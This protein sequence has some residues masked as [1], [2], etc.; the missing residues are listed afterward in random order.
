MANRIATVLALLVCMQVARAQVRIHSHND[1]FRDTP[2]FEAYNQRVGSIECDMYLVDGVFLVGHDADKLK[3]E[4]TFEALY[5]DPVVGVFRKNGGCAWSSD[6]DNPLQLMIDVKSRDKKGFMNALVERLDRYPEVFDPAVNPRACKVLITGYF[7]HEEGCGAYPSYIY[8]DYGNTADNLN[9][10]HLSH[11]LMFSPCFR[12]FSKWN[13]KG[14]IPEKEKELI[15]EQVSRAHAVGKLIRFWA[16][17]DTPLAWNTLLDLGVDY[18]NTDHV[19]DCSTYFKNPVVPMTAITGKPR[20]KDVEELLSLYHEVGMEQ[21]LIYP[22]SGLEIEYMSKD[23]FRFCRDCIEVADS[24]GMKVWLY[25]EYNWP[26]GNC[27]G[28]VTSGGRSDLYPQILMFDNDGA[29]NYSTRVV[30]NAIGADILN[31]EAVSRFIKFTHERYFEAF[32]PYFGKVIRAIFTDEPSFSYSMSSPSGM[33]ESNFTGFDKNHFALTWYEGLEEDYRRRVGSDLHEDVIAY[34]HGKESGKLWMAYFNL[35][36]DRMRTIY[37]DAL[38]SWCES[39][40]I[41]LTG[42]LEYEKLYKSVRCNGNAL[43]MLSSFGLPGL[44]EANSDIALD[45]RE[46][47]VSGL[48]L[49]QYARQNRK[50][51]MAE[52]YSVGPAD[53][54]VS[55]MRQVMWMCAAFGVDNYVSAVS[56]FDARGNV[57]K[58]DWY[59]PSGPTQPWYDF[60]REFCTEAARAAH[61]ARKPYCPEVRVR[62]PSSWFMS[63]DKTPAFEEQGKRYL[64]FL[65]G[66]LS[67]QLQFMLLDEDEDSTGLPVLG[68]GPDGFHMEGEIGHYDDAEEFLAHVCTKVK[69]SIVVRDASGKEVRDV[70]VRRW[71]DGTITLV[72]LTDNDSLDRML[73]VETAEGRGTVRLLGHGVYAGMVSVSESPSSAECLDMSGARFIADSTNLVRCIFNREEPEFRFRLEGRTRL[74][75]LS[76]SAVH[77]VC[78]TLAPADSFRKNQSSLLPFVRAKVAAGLCPSGRSEGLVSPA[79]R[80]PFGFSG[81]YAQSEWLELPKGEY[82]LRFEGDAVDYRYLPAAFLEGDFALTEEGLQPLNRGRGVRALTTAEGYSGYVGTYSIEKIFRSLPERISL[83]TNLACTELL[84]DGESLGRCAWGPFEWDVPEKYRRGRHTVTVR[85]CTNIM[86]LFGDLKL[87]EKDQPYIPWLRIKPGMHGNKVV[88]G[89]L[90]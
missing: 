60:Y 72:D 78:L 23:W 90:Q 50:S 70:L 76:R 82:I 41:E 8:Y 88:T 12:T 67:H 4:N 20:R 37:I 71:A 32:A 61:F 46:M 31:P 14:P 63:L 42:H 39:H 68:F 89:I 55:I 40:G 28:E 64:R 33:L 80:L 36:G 74:R 45:A 27:R 83:N 19:I 30:H 25:D 75:I 59:F 24:L 7:P 10:E 53:N 38:A 34:L 35:L 57:E 1:Y 69:R 81:L 26:S 18:V 11:V 87:L 56:A 66:L 77:P 86:P 15:R 51:A 62:V 16:V 13:G 65:E 2:F 21:F 79:T 85:I 58:G 3:S 44:D 43:K 17:P 84:V 6:P 47:E 48:A 22:R 52:L 5:L 49:V 54:P 9:E 29:G 73:S